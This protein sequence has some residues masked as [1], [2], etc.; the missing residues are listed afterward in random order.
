MASR[1]CLHD[2][3][4][5]C[6]DTGMSDRI[7]MFAS[8]WMVTHCCYPKRL[9]RGPSARKGKPKAASA[10]HERMWTEHP[11]SRVRTGTR[12]PKNANVGVD[13]DTQVRR[14][15]GLARK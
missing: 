11:A 13:G 10:C 15:R 14:T 4:C 12:T 1:L 8:V 6:S 9:A 3:D 5:C 7:Y 2:S